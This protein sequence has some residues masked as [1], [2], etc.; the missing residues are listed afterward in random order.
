MTG[1]PTDRFD[2]LLL[3]KKSIITPKHARPIQDFA[4]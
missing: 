1:P 4:Y 2:G 3:K